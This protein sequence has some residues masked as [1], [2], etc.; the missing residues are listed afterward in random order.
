[1]TRIST[2]RKPR[3][4]SIEFREIIQC[5]TYHSIPPYLDEDFHLQLSG[6]CRN[7]H[8]MV[9][10]EDHCHILQLRELHSGICNR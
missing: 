1:M 4:L 7:V 5:T 2:T 8:M 6:R 9:G 10:L 3:L